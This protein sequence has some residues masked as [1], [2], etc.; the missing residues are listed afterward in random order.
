MLISPNS[1]ENWSLSSNFYYQN[2]LPQQIQSID[3]NSK[4]INWLHNTMDVEKIKTLDSELIRFQIQNLK[5]ILE[6]KT[7]TKNLLDSLQEKDS[8]GVTVSDSFFCF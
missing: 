7:F 2:N 3:F 4:V 8:T 6:Q 1:I 5:Q